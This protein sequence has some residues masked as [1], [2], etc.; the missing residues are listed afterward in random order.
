MKT[1]IMEGLSEQEQTELRS[2][3]VASLRLRRRIEEILRKDIDSLVVSM[4]NDEHFQ[5]D[6]PYVQ[7]D[8]VAQIKAMRKII[9]LFSE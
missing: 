3:W 4:C 6:W 7:A 9:S 5:S 1:R 8:R 2:E